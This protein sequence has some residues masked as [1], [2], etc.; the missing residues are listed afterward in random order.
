MQIPQMQ[1]TDGFTIFLRF[2]VHIKAVHIMSMKTTP[3]DIATI[4]SISSQEV[5]DALQE[6]TEEAKKLEQRN[7]EILAAIRCKPL[8][9]NAC[10]KKLQRLIF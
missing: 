8:L 4:E 9:M 7:L 1:K 2:S 5:F 6:A 3:A 10:Y